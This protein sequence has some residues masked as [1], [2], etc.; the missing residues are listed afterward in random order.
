MSL[1]DIFM[2]AGAAL[3]LVGEVLFAVILHKG[4]TTTFHV[5]YYTGK[6]KVFSAACVM[7]AVWFVGHM[8]AGWPP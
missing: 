6:H 1:S 2:L 3:W 5:R 4:K 7:F 8:L